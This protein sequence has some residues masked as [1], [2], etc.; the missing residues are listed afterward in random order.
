MYR[1]VKAYFIYD[2]REEQLYMEFANE[3]ENEAATIAAVQHQAVQESENLQRAAP[4][5]RPL[6]TPPTHQLMSPEYRSSL[7]EWNVR[8]RVQENHSAGESGSN[9]DS[10]N[11]P[12]LP[13][14]PR[15]ESFDWMGSGAPT[16]EAINLNHTSREQLEEPESRIVKS[17]QDFDEGEE[18]SKNKQIE[19]TPTLSIEVPA[20]ARLRSFELT[21]TV[22]KKVIDTKHEL[23]RI[24]EVEEHFDNLD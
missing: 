21:P 24:E 23:N 18:V 9:P 11:D 16:L 10:I 7:A 3:L 19:S 1:V 13:R 2:K 17:I 5:A 14:P 12:P 6:V 4:V 15:T 20:R 8:S 22:S